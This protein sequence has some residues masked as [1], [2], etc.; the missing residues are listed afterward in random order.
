MDQIA[1]TIEGVILLVC[2][3]CFLCFFVVYCIAQK[4]RRDYYFEYEERKRK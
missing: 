4:K 1:W 3:I 2:I